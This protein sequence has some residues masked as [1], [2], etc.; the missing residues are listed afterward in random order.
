MSS[1]QIRLVIG[2]LSFLLVAAVVGRL[3]ASGWE[4]NNH[5]QTSTLP[6]T[7]TDR[8]I[9]KFVHVDDQLLAGA[10]EDALNRILR[11]T[12]KDPSMIGDM[13]KSGEACWI[14]PN[15]KLQLIQRTDWS[16]QVRVLSPPEHFWIN[17]DAYVLTRHLKEGLHPAFPD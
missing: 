7:T 9:A 13:K 14:G 10:S 4:S 3:I 15:C 16:S 5:L 12:D 2:V 6:S 11:F 17:Q 8:P 1:N